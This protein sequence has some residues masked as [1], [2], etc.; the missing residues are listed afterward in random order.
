V[1]HPNKIATCCHCGTKAALKLDQ[2]QHT[3]VCGACGA[4]L[5][6]LKMVPRPVAQKPAV[7]HQPQLRK[8]AKPARPP[9]AAKP[10]R[11]KAKKRKGWFGK[12]FKDLAEDVFD[13]VEDIFD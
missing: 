5:R 9:E 4:P 2:T 6:D 8:F 12:R 3:L 1:A 11:K 7:T 10:K 13:V